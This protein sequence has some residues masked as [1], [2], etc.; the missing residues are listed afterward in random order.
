MGLL[1]L[2]G[3]ARVLIFT[4]ILLITVS[5]WPTRDLKNFTFWGET[6]G[7]DSKKLK[8]NGV[9]FKIEKRKSNQFFNSDHVR[10]F[11][12]YK[13]GSYL[14]ML[15][16][17]I[18]Y[19]IDSTI[20]FLI[21]YRPETRQ[22]ISNWGA[23]KIVGDTLFLQRYHHFVMPKPGT[24]TFTSKIFSYNTKILNDT[25]LVEIKENSTDGYDEGKYYLF[26]TTNKPDSTN[27]FMTNKR[28]KRKL[29]RLY[30][31]RHRNDK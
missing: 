1:R 21:Q 17:E 12:L 10:C 25:T 9:Y 20:N 14:D 3:L 31:R 30:E 19:S 26:K 24:I 23:F 11:V 22:S 18:N 28:I 6:K 13:N 4:F 15:S 27:L 5:C 7:V 29:D 16:A 8:I 2:I